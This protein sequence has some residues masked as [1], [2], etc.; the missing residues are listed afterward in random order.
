M[1]CEPF[2]S[3]GRNNCCGMQFL[4]MERDGTKNTKKKNKKEKRKGN[5]RS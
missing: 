1:S 3:S 2:R 5:V 4:L